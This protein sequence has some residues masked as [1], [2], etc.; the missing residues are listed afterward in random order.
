MLLVSAIAF[1]ATSMCYAAS[2]WLFPLLGLLDFP[3]RYGLLRQRLPYPTG[4]IAAC[5]S[6]MLIAWSLPI[7]MKVWG[8]IIGVVML[9]TICFIDDRT[10]L[11]PLVRLIAQ[12]V[13]IG[14][15]VAAGSRIYTITHPF[16]GFIKL[17]AWTIELPLVGTT[18]V[19]ASLMT[20]AWLLLTTNALNWFDGIDGQV[21][22]VATIGFVLL[23]FLAA[24]RNGEMDIAML[25]F[26]LGAV[27]GAGIFFSLPPARMIIGDTGAMLFG[28]LLGVLGVMQGGKVATVILALGIPLLD[29]IF[30]VI[31]RVVQKQSPLKGGRD[32][33][34]HLL[35]RAGFAPRSIIAIMSIIGGVFGGAALFLSTNG[36]ALMVLL[37]ALI[38]MTLR[39][40]LVSH[41]RRYPKNT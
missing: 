23:G 33:L 30:V 36:K 19:I 2:L 7:S 31:M 12:C 24:I 21:S 10:P 29:A 14:I 27:T 35:L 8:V 11:P 5:M 4:I 38:V 40:W 6:V 15:I 3:E 13:A 26:G 28:L 41:L 39:L 22:V 18:P 34:H 1:V 16:G 25:A 32:H 9:I 20:G 17:D 37:L